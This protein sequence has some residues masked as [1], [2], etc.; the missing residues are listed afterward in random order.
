MISYFHTERRV[1]FADVDLAGIVSFTRFFTFM[2]TAEHELLRSIGSSVHFEL[3][4]QQVGWPRTS[5]SCEY[6]QPAKFEDVLDIEVRILRKG[7]RSMTYQFNFTRGSEL[8]AR[9]QLSS[10]C[11]IVDPNK[12]LIPIEIPP[13][14]ADELQ[15]TEP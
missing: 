13:F 6:F 4:G 14:I 10:A 1:E 11:C 8:I 5:A 3:N 12:G 15:E 2:E 7:R 9:G